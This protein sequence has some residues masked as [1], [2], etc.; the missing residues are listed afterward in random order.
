ME[1][2]EKRLIE[3]MMK[4]SRRKTAYFAG[5]ILKKIPWGDSIFDGDCERQSKWRK[6]IIDG[7]QYSKCLSWFYKSQHLNTTAQDTEEIL[8]L[9][10]MLA[11]SYINK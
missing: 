4:F 1:E 7:T 10:I 6:E 2:I 8:L 11:R 5:E 9:L 3:T